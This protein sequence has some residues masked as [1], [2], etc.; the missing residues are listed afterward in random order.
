MSTDDIIN[1]LKPGV[2]EPLT[3]KPDGTI[4]DGNTRIT[5]VVRSISA[6]PSISASPGRV[7]LATVS[8]LSDFVFDLTV[9]NVSGQTQTLGV[10]IHRKNGNATNVYPTRQV[11][12][13]RKTFKVEISMIHALPRLSQA[14]PCGWP[15]RVARSRGSHPKSYQTKSPAM[16]ARR[17]NASLP[18]RRC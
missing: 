12:R 14:P 10:T 18:V 1:S 16:V 2:Q 6:C 15:S 9:R 5:G 4:M 13:T 8:H 7:V 3:V 11:S 17:A